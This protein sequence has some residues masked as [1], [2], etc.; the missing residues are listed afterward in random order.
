MF[1]DDSANIGMRS[2]VD[3][4]FRVFDLTL[5]RVTLKKITC[6]TFW[7]SLLFILIASTLP[8]YSYI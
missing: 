1:H 8:R 6:T 4:Y 7:Y 3:I 2:G 5:N